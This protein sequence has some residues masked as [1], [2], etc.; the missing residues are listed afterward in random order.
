MPSTQEESNRLTTYTYLSNL[1]PV[2][3]YLPKGKRLTYYAKIPIG[4]QLKIAV[5]TPDFTLSDGSG[6]K[7]PRMY[8]GKSGNNTLTDPFGGLIYI[9]FI[10][11]SNASG[12]FA[13]M[14]GTESIP[15]PVFVHYMKGATV[16]YR[17]DL[18]KY[19]ESPYVEFVSRHAILTVRR[20]DAL[21]HKDDDPFELMNAY[22]EI[23][24]VEDR[25]LGLEGSGIHRVGPLRHHFVA[26]GNQ[27][28][29]GYA[30]TSTDDYPGWMAFHSD[31]TDDLLTSAGVRNSWGI[32][33]ELG[34]QHQENPLFSLMTEGV[35]DAEVTV[36]L[37]AGAVQRHFKKPSR[38]LE[39]GSSG[40]DIWKEALDK[41]A[42]GNVGAK[43]MSPWH[44]LAALEQLRLAYGDNFWVNVH[45]MIRAENI[46]SRDSATYLALMTSRQAGCDLRAFFRGWGFDISATADTEIVKLGFPECPSKIAAMREPAA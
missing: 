21:R 25:Y 9:A 40:N 27:A 6:S 11:N 20:E 30:Y 33:H 36:N 31:F 13:A 17:E 29:I 3:E 4:T 15:S 10:G 41:R 16:R 18:A 22:E 38:L 14:E 44:K 39:S 37:F 35:G 19:T 23:I 43:S 42:A 24:D 46:N 45:R 5:G 12:E 2:G 34:H 1:S 26:S 7:V 8:D 28:G 32:W